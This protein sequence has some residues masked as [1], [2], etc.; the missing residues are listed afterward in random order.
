MPAAA[1]EERGGVTSD[2]RKGIQKDLILFDIRSILIDL[3]SFDIRSNL[4]D[5]RSTASGLLL[6]RGR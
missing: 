2:W 6:R 4:C 1:V 5:L 3:M